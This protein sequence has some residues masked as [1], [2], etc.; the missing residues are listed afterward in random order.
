M[1]LDLYKE[2]LISS[3]EKILSNEKIEL[4]TPP[5]L[6][7][8]DFALPCFKFA[9]TYKKAPPLISKDLQTKLQNENEI[10]EIFEFHVV[11]PYLNFKIKKECLIQDLLFE[12]IYNKENLGFSKTQNKGNVVVEF[13]SPNIAKP[14]NIYHLRS[15]MIGNA[16]S[17]ILKARGYTPIRIN[18]LGDWGTQFGFLV[19]AY[20]RYGNEEDLN[21]RGIEYL[22][23]LYVKINKEAE[24]DTEIENLARKRFA[25][26]EQQDPAITKL[27]QKF[28]EL[29]LREYEK[30]YKRLNV[31]FDYFWGESFY[32]EQIPNLIK[33]LKEK[34]LLKESQGALI[35]DLEN[36]KM[37]PCIIQKADGSS[38]YATRDLAAAIYRYEKFQFKKMIYVVGAEQKLHFQQIFKVLELMQYDWAKNCIHV[39]F[40]LYRF[41]NQDGSFSKMSTRKG[42]FITLEAVL[43]EAVNEVKTLIE[44][45]IENNLVDYKMTSEEIQKNAEAIGCGAIIFN[46]LSTDRNIDVNFDLE[47]VLDFNGET[48][49]YIQYA[50]TR[51]LS[52][53]RN[54]PIELQKQLELITDFKEKNSEI[55][56]DNQNKLEAIKTRWHGWTKNLNSKI[57]QELEELNLIRTLAKLPLVLDQ[58]LENYKPSILANFLIDVTKSFNTFYRAHKVLVDDKEIAFSRLCL[59]LAT[60]NVLYQGCTLLGMKLP[61]RM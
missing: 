46:D 3:L 28:V 29:S 52:I 33:L 38:I 26:L 23:E 57:F 15:T 47:K 48:G 22:V 50:H 54:A 5:E 27:W 37:P 11:G 43:D 1:S 18:H 45:K 4:E 60:K 13:S 20:E 55:P 44:S 32:I 19:L 58:V 40:G 49:P 21:A 16:L 9:K 2:K 42:K 6:S 59:V 10:S 53:L 7:L 31:E 17:R 30:T 41:A 36:E 24:N 12:L 34:N 14:F 51:C 39:D 56:N 35:V 25:K 8:G 61:D